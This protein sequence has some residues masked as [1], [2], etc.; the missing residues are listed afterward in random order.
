MSREY[1]SL[2]PLV[3]HRRQP[4]A[5]WVFAGRDPAAARRRLRRPREAERRRA[6]RGEREG[7]L[8]LPGVPR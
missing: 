2:Q 5:G 1:P 8:V 6:E 4:C 7:Q 3:Q